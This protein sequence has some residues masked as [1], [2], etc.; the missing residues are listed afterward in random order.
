MRRL[1]VLVAPAQAPPHDE[2]THPV[3][4]LAV[5]VAESAWLAVQTLAQLI[6][7]VPFVTVPLPEKVEM[8]SVWP[9]TTGVDARDAVPVPAR[10]VA[11][12]VNVYA[13]PFV[14]PVIVQ[15]SGPLVHEHVCP[16]GFA[17]TV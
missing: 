16:P 14:N 9:C 6:V 17:V 11:A 2:K 13:I 4:G 3:A 10:F 12:T 5:M 7:P 8:E 15:E 1:H